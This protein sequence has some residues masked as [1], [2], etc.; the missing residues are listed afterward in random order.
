MGIWFPRKVHRNRTRIDVR[1]DT[2]IGVLVNGSRLG[3]I[4]IPVAVSIAGC[5]T[6][7]LTPQGPILGI[8]DRNGPAPLAVGNDLPRLAYKR[9]VARI[10]ARRRKG[11][12][13]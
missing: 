4:E 11:N 5:I 7:V 10:A 6:S 12:C 9:E 1:H 8:L 13:F 3:R 2:H